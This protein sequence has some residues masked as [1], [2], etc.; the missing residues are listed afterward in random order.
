MACNEYV[1]TNAPVS[2]H[3]SDTYN[4]CILFMACNEYVITHVPVPCPGSDTYN[5][6]I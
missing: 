1:I 3:V 5:M 2:C 6:C 4:I